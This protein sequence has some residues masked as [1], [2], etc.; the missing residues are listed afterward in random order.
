MNSS[1]NKLKNSNQIDTKKSPLLSCYAP[2][3][4]QYI[5]YAMRPPFV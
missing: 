2:K 4:N 5:L 3:Y 1:I